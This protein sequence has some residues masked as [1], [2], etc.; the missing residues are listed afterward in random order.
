LNAI[1]SREFGITA[2]IIS[3]GSLVKLSGI[4]SQR[5]AGAAEAKPWQLTMSST[6]IQGHLWV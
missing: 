1:T 2:K 6:I 5:G 3:H 4:K